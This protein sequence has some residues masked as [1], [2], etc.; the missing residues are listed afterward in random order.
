MPIFR[1]IVRKLCLPRWSSHSAVELI[2]SFLHN[3]H[4]IFYLVG[5]SVRYIFLGS[6]YLRGRVLWLVWALFFVFNRH[7]KKNIA[8]EKYLLISND[9]YCKNVLCNISWL[10]THQVLAFFVYIFTIAQL[11]A[12]SNTLILLVSL[13]LLRENL[14]EWQDCSFTKSQPYKMLHNFWTKFDY[15]GHS[16]MYLSPCLQLVC[17]TWGTVLAQN[18]W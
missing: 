13:V 3:C 12:K 6:K 2:V 5:L 10:P 16:T 11:L 1:V 18:H 8:I 7:L 9:F 15:S 4:T 14:K 17:T